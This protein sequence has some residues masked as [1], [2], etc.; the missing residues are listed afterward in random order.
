M[1]HTIMEYWIKKYRIWTE[2]LYVCCNVR[3]SHRPGITIR[4][5]STLGPA[6]TCVPVE[7]KGSPYF[8]PHFEKRRQTPNIINNQ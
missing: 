5:K 1:Q 2:P 8:E 7:I 4:Q 3:I 6:P